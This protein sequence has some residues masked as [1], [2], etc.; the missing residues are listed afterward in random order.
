LIDQS[1]VGHSD[2]NTASKYKSNE[3]AGDT[4]L[5]SEDVAHKRGLRSP[6]PLYFSIDSVR[7][8]AISPLSVARY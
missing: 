6:S 2:S 7:A 8:L 1:S 5:R 3:R 4:N